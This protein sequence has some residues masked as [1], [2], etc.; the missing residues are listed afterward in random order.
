V[1]QMNSVQF[2]LSCIFTTGV[3]SKN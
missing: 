3:I 2:W 1:T